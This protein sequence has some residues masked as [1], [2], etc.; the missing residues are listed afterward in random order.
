MTTTQ[1]KTRYNN[2]RQNPS[3][4]AWTS[5]HSRNKS[6]RDMF[7]CTVIFHKTTKL[8]AIEYLHRILRKLIQNIE[9]CSFICIKIKVNSEHPFKKSGFMNIT[10]VLFS[11]SQNSPLISENTNS[12]LIFFLD[13]EM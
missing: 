2:R 7:I 12:A 13:Y 1:D 10:E 4:L 6:V 5:Q 3:Y 9:K 8:V 11:I